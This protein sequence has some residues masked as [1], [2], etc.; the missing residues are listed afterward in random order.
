ME[1]KFNISL[2]NIGYRFQ[3]E[4]LL[5]DCTKINDN[6]FS[7]ITSSY[8]KTVLYVLLFDLYNND[9]NLNIRIYKYLLGLYNYRIYREM[10]SILYNNYL[11]IALSA[12]DS[13]QCDYTTEEE[14]KN[15]FSLLVIFNYVNSTDSFI[16]IYPYLTDNKIESSYSNNLIF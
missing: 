2:N 16:E 12:C 4:P 13:L 14:N 11:T 8:D 7:L 1:E 3:T 6:R 15:Y 9:S 5:S 10:T